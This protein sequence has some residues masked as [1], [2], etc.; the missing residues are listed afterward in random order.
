MVAATHSPTLS[1]RAALLRIERLHE[2]WRSADDALAE[3]ELRLCHATLHAPLEQV[4]ATVGAETVRLRA[5]ARTAWHAL[6]EAIAHS[7][8]AAPH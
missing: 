6:A 4:R 8:D 1:Q 5:V 7:E 2:A 3:A